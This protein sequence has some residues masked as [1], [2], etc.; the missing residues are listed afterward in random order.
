ME[1]KFG[2]GKFDEMSHFEDKVK[3]SLANKRS[4]NRLLII[5]IISTDLDGFSLANHG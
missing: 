2:G 1:R 3:E 5:L 4:A